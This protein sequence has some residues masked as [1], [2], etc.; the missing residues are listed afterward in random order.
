MTK[1]ENFVAIR[2]I[3][4]ASGNS[5]FDAFINHEIELLSK[6]RTSSKKPTKVQIANEG[7]KQT[8]LGV[9]GDEGVTVTE[10]MGMIGDDTLT[11]QKVSAVLRLMKDNDGTI[12]KEVV[13]GKS[14][15]SLA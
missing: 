1:K 10:I 12:K 7:L 11:N 4:N 15:F 5:D 6:K 14:L 9:L 3:L 13:K 8:I 2:E